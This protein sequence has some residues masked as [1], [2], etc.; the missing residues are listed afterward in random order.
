MA[1]KPIK[2][3][4]AESVTSTDTAKSRTTT[5]NDGE[6]W[7][8]RHFTVDKT[9]TGTGTLSLEVN[10]MDNEE[11]AQTVEGTAGAT[12][13]AKE[14]AN[15]TG[16]APKPFSTPSDTITITSANPEQHTISVRTR[17]KRARLT[18]TNATGTVV[19]TVRMS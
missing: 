17:A 13:E 9:N 7:L 1:N 15:T 5:R 3:F 16:W 8:I 11:Y 14:A 19:L 2:V 4:D 12:F 6:T 18:Y 10:D